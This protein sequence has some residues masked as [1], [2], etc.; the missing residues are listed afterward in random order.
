MKAH[1]CPL[2]SG[3]GGQLLVRAAEWRIVLADEPGW[4]GFARVIWD[5]H[6]GEMSDL[7]PTQ[8]SELMRTV[9]ALESVMRDVLAPDKVNLASLGNQVPHLHWH[10][11]PRYRDD[12]HF[13]APVWAAPSRPPRPADP[14]LIARFRDAVTAYFAPHAAG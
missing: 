2:C 1:A 6:V 9:C 13:P 3:D 5:R 12:S 14:A 11:I 7:A 8:R 4:P 10:V